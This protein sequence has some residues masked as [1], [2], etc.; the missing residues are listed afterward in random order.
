MVDDEDNSYFRELHHRPL[1]D[2]CKP[3]DEVSET[4][5]VAVSS[6]CQEDAT[7]NIKYV[8]DD[9]NSCYSY[10]SNTMAATS[11]ASGWSV[12][13]PGSNKPRILN[14]SGNSVKSVKSVQSGSKDSSIVSVAS[15]DA[16]EA[17][18][19]YR[20]ICV[21]HKLSTPSMGGG[22]V[23]GRQKN[24]RALADTLSMV[25]GSEHAE[26]A[27]DVSVDVVEGLRHAE[28]ACEASA[29]APPP[30]SPP[31]PPLTPHP[32]AGGTSHSK[33]S[34][35][36]KLKSTKFFG[37]KSNTAKSDVGNVQSMINLPYESG[38]VEL[39]NEADLPSYNA[40]DGDRGADATDETLSISTEITMNRKQSKSTSATVDMSLPTDY[41]VYNED[42]KALVVKTS[43]LNEEHNPGGLLGKMLRFSGFPFQCYAGGVEDADPLNSHSASGKLA[44][45]LHD[46]DVDESLNVEAYDDSD[47]KVTHIG[48]FDREV[49]VDSSVQNSPEENGMAVTSCVIFKT[50]VTPGFEILSENENSHRV[51]DTLSLTIDDIARRLNKG[52]NHVPL[53]SKGIG[54]RAKLSAKLK[55]LN[56]KDASKTKQEK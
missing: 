32:F 34:L 28:P 35:L 14:K 22:I 52:R 33:F 15:M 43:S 20:E 44:L 9:N 56:R 41:A 10:S 4:A 42:L 12:S 29:D 27:R 7:R 37:R 46:D 30:P 49:M 51:V 24:G 25:E 8:L 55:S 48:F 21:T 3:F 53:E 54:F 16:K 36:G 38:E 6:E 19:A 13:S 23:D 5:A 40:P 2:D 11:I 31:L 39:I 18:E 50:R 47:S 17:A 1:E 26:P 45:L